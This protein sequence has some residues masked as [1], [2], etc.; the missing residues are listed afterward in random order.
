MASD[1]LDP[2]ATW[3]RSS[4]ACST[5]HGKIG[6]SSWSS[7]C[8]QLSTWHLMFLM[9]PRSTITAFSTNPFES[10][11]PL[12]ASSSVTSALKFSATRDERD[13][14][15]LCVASQ[16]DLFVP[17]RVDESCH[18]LACPRFFH[19]LLQDYAAHNV[20]MSVLLHR[21]ARH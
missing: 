12:T 7:S 3:T 15:P 4:P 6:E 19:S 16:R 5:N 2:S 13:C 11:S 14:F 1:H 21:N 9:T 18:S 20:L 10:S 17:Q 8:V